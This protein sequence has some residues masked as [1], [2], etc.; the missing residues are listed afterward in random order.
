VLGAEAA[1]KAAGEHRTALTDAT[2]EEAARCLRRPGTGPA[3]MHLT[4]S[5]RPRRELDL[6]GTL[7]VPAL[8]IGG[9]DDRICP[10]SSVCTV[11]ELLGGELRMLDDVG[12][13]AHEQAPD[14]VDEL[15]TAFVESVG[16]PGGR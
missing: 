9:T 8:V 1:L 11:A 5:W 3:L 4:T 12:H 2:A 15:V 6:L 14:V 7:D 16:D 10:P 13:A